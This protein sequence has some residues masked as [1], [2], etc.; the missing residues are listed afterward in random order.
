MT[1]MTEDRMMGKSRVYKFIYPGQIQVQ[2]EPLIVHVRR[3]VF[4]CTVFISNFMICY[5]NVNVFEDFR[6]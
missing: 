6:L 4:S 5:E 2:V 3:Q 1:K